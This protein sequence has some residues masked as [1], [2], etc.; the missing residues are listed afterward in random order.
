MLAIVLCLVLCAVYGQLL[1]QGTV[2]TRDD[3]LL[4][5]PL[6]AVRK[7]SDFFAYLSANPDIQPV[8]DL[9]WM[10]DVFVYRLSGLLSFHAHNLLLWA[11]ICWIFYRILRQQGVQKELASA[12]LFLFAVHPLFVMTV[13]W[14]SAH[15]HLLALFFLLLGLKDF[16]AYQQDQQE[17]RL[18]RLPLWHLLSILSQPIYLFFPFWMVLALAPAQWKKTKVRVAMGVSLVASVGILLLNYLH[19]A[20]A[21]A[22]NPIRSQ[23]LHWAQV[24]SVSEP[25]LQL[26]RYFYNIFVPAH[27]ATLYRVDTYENSVG[28]A[29]FVLFYAGMGKV[30]GWKRTGLWA[31]FG[32]GSLGI[33]LLKLP[34]HLASDTY[35]LG[36]AVSCFFLVAFLGQKI[37]KQKKTMRLASGLLLVLALPLAWVAQRESQQ[38]KTDFLLWENAY[39]RQPSCS[40]SLNYSLQLFGAHREAEAILV[41]AQHLRNHCQ[42]EFS[43]YLFGLLLFYDPAIP[44]QERERLLWSLEAHPK[45]PR[46]LVVVYLLEAGREKEAVTKLRALPEYSVA[47]YPRFLRERLEPTLRKLCAKKAACPEDLLAQFE[48]AKTKPDVVSEPALFFQQR[49]NL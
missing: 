28:L 36:L 34:S 14:I 49:R 48:W 42:E 25:L 41:G 24:L 33:V 13:G 15:K 22:G 46:L 9:S 5:P 12:L 47:T 17:R 32:L 31:L 29:I 19:Y 8:R 11:A 30:L 4:L 2:L 18:W 44:K 40:A 1:W 27:Y 21:Y 45:F 38:W 16:L 10:L 35:A 3:N 23:G 37:L 20:A 43:P 6:F 39:R 26:G 7:I